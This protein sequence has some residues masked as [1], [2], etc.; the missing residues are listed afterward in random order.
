[1]AFDDGP[2]LFRE[3]RVARPEQVPEQ[4]VE[5]PEVHVVVVVRQVAVA[6][7]GGAAAREVGLLLGRR[8]FFRDG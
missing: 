5:E 1:V 7:E 3:L 8:E 4:G 6:V 2:H